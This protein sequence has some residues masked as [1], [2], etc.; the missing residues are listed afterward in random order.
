MWVIK[1]EWDWFQEMESE[2][3][4][5]EIVVSTFRRFSNDAEIEIKI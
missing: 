2:G 5:R 1:K 4:T 3:R